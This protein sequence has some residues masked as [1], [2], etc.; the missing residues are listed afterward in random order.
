MPLNLFRQ[1]KNSSGKM[2]ALRPI[3]ATQFVSSIKK[4]QWQNA[5]SQAHSYRSIFYVFF[6]FFPIG[7]GWLCLFLKQKIKA[8]CSKIHT[9]S[10]RAPTSICKEL[11]FIR[12]VAGWAGYNCVQ[13]D[14]L[15][16]WQFTYFYTFHF[17]FN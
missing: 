8:P 4:F 17:L 15:L 3:H 16:G 1:L 11:L 14:E 7:Y 10:G 12:K 5:G 9:I 13:I 6:T 2:W